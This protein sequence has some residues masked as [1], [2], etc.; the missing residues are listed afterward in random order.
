MLIS[1]TNEKIKGDARIMEILVTKEEQAF[2]NIG[3]PAVLFGKFNAQEEEEE[4]AKAIENGMLAEDFAKK[5]EV[6]EQEFDPLELLMGN[7]DEKDTKVEFGKEETL[8]SDIDYVRNAFNVFTDT[9]S[10]KLTEMASVEGVEIKMTP[11]LK[12]KMSKLLPDEA[13]P[14]DDVLR[15]SNTQK[16]RR[17]LFFYFLSF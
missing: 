3:D 15:L 13:M 17:L 7:V 14:S 12:R 11:E 4:T 8:F 2:K 5:L 16:D 1:S 6:S 10:F 9:E